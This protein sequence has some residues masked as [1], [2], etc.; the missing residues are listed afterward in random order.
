LGLTGAEASLPAWTN[1]MRAATASRPALDFV[2]PAG[3]GLPKSAPSLE[4]ATPGN[5][6][7]GVDADADNT[8]D[9]SD[10]PND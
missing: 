1:F 8:D 10:S 3:F 7:Q 5:P 6:A 2:A 9:A 4:D